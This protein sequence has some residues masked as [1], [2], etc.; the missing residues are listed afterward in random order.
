[1][2]GI[3]SPETF[4]GKLDCKGARP[5]LK[6]NCECNNDEDLVLVGV[7]K[8]SSNLLFPVIR[9]AI[10]CP[11]ELLVPPWLN[12]MLQD[13]ASEPTKLKMIANMLN[14]MPIELHQALDMIFQNHDRLEDMKQHIQGVQKL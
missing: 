2:S 7:Q 9:N 3:L 8:S 4:S 1:M 11:D 10:F 12:D 5:W 13:P 14:I 6:T